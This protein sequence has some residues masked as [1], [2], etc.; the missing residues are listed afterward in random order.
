MERTTFIFNNELL[1]DVKFVVPVSTGESESNKM[2]PTHKFVLAICSPVFL[3]HVLWSTG[4][5]QTVNYASS[6]VCTSRDSMVLIVEIGLL[7]GF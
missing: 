7:Q 1:S 5:V 2:I 6:K 4:G 3:W